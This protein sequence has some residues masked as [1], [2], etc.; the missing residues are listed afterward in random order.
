MHSCFSPSN[1]RLSLALALFF[2]IFF[3]GQVCFFIKKLALQV[4]SA[5]LYSLLI[6]FTQHYIFLC[7]YIY[8]YIR[9]CVRVFGRSNLTLLWNFTCS[10][11]P[12][13]RVLFPE[14]SLLLRVPPVAHRSMDHPKKVTRAQLMKAMATLVQRCKVNPRGETSCAKLDA[15]LRYRTH[16]NKNLYH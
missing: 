6:Y 8:I 16:Q 12:L 5:A 4:L 2:Y 10:E 15:Q 14:S 13:L 7:I 1:I 9:I 3:N 11:F